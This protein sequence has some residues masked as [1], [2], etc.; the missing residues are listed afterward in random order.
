MHEISGHYI[1]IYV[2]PSGTLAKNQG[3]TPLQHAPGDS[4]TSGEHG[5]TNCENTE[6]NQGIQTWTKLKQNLF[7]NNFWKS[8]KNY[9]E[10]WPQIRNDH[11]QWAKKSNNATVPERAILDANHNTKV[12]IRIHLPWLSRWVNNVKIDRLRD[13]SG[14]NEDGSCKHMQSSTSWQFWSFWAIL[15]CW[16]DC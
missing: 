13:F 7:L 4:T 3:L 5:K 8:H 16:K 14:C 11:F 6:E 15:K 9:Q 10:K 2:L 1:Y 12:P